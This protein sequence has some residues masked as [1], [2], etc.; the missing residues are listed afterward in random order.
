MHI[1]PV[2]PPINEA[3]FAEALRLAYAAGTDAVA[4]R[5][6]RENRGPDWLPDDRLLAVDT[7][8]RTMT[9]AGFTELGQITLSP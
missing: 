3:A 5:Q 4:A 1:A 7:W 8:N 6:R 9:L 2:Q